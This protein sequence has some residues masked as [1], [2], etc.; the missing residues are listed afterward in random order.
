[1]VEIH[2]SGSYTRLIL[3][4]PKREP[5]RGGAFVYISVPA[6]LGTDEAH[7]FSVALRGPPPNVTLPK[8]ASP[9]DVHTLYIKSLGP[10]TRALQSSARGAEASCSP[11]SLLVDVDG[12]YNHIDS[13]A[14][15]MVDGIPRVVLV[16]GGSGITPFL[17]LLQVY[18]Y[19]KYCVSGGGS[20]DE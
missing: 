3:H 2:A 1:M 12:F 13:F 8:S 17:C 7:A 18:H 10:W 11:K 19:K 15:M 4:N 16:A 14:S 20:G 9:D 6:A 5:A